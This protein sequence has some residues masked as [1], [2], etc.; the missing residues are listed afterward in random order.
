MISLSDLQVSLGPILSL[1]DTPCWNLIDSI[2]NR[3]RGIFCIFQ[4][5]RAQKKRTLKRAL[6]KKGIFLLLEFHSLPEA[7]W[8]QEIDPKTWEHFSDKKSKGSQSQYPG[9]VLFVC[10]IH[11]CKSIG[12]FINCHLCVCFSH[13]FE[14]FWRYLPIFQSAA[15]FFLETAWPSL[16]KKKPGT[17]SFHV[18]TSDYLNVIRCLRFIFAILKILK[19]DNSLASP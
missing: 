1:I 18:P 2:L 8:T 19:T 13:N 12:P 16:L 4:A 7:Q 10:C 6:R 11:C 5:Q 17:M 14:T 3:K 9:S 15:E